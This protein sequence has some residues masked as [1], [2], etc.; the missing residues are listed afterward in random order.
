[1]KQQ[2]LEKPRQKKKKQHGSLG[3]M[4]HMSKPYLPWFIFQGMNINK[5]K[6]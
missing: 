6:G 1:M 5:S 2:G 3:H 4:S